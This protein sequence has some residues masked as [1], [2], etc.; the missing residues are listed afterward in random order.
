[1]ICKICSVDQRNDVAMVCMAADKNR[2]D[3]GAGQFFVTFTNKTV[4]HLYRSYSVHPKHYWKHI[5]TRTGE[6]IIP[7]HG[8]IAAN[9][10]MEERV[11]YKK[12]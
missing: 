8:F 11:S 1:M 3:R 5:T 6:R 10:S 9:K 2:Y 4:P 12:C 7:I